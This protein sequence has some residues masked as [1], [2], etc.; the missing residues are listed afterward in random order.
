M[1]RAWMAIALASQ[2][3]GCAH[4]CGWWVYGGGEVRVE[5]AGDDGRTVSWV[6]PGVDQRAL[7]LR[8]SELVS[9]RDDDRVDSIPDNGSW[10]EARVEEP[11]G[12][13]MRR[14]VLVGSGAPNPE[15]V[16]G[17]DAWL[18][19]Q[20]ELEVPIPGDGRSPRVRSLLFTVEN[21]DGVALSLG[22]DHRFDVAVNDDPAVQGNA[23]HTDD[24]PFEGVGCDLP[25]SGRLTVDWAFDEDLVADG[26]W[27]CTD[28]AP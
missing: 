4:D 14:H 19:L 7:D 22:P 16:C 17:P 5:L 2:L 1:G 6:L 15:G 11:R 3:V 12:G 8:A 28:A 18:E 25:E 26:V 27:R 24:V 21:G 23:Q 20:A 13:A 10:L 9:G